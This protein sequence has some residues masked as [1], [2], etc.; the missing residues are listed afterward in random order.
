MSA[1]KE[2]NTK[3]ITNPREFVYPQGTNV[4]IQ[5]YLLTDLIMIFE[6]L[7]TEEVKVE[8]KFKY[9]YVNEKGNIVKT[10][11]AADIEAGKVAKHLDFNRT[12]MEPNLEYS[13][14][15]K[16]IAYA[17][18]KN[19][20]ESIHFKNIQEGKAVSYAELS[21]NM[22]VDSNTEEKKD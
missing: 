10:P 21:K 20:L 12:I 18:L 2:T 7:L 11:K 17:E 4:E 19:F 8:S 6:K 5:G 1:T 9:S 16:G 3:Q 14:T 22:V 13:I 15:E